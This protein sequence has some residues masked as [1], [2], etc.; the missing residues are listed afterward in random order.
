MIVHCEGCRG[1]GPLLVTPTE[2]VVCSCCG[3]HLSHETLV[4]LHRL[5]VTQLFELK[6]PPHVVQFLVEQRMPSVAVQFF[7]DLPRAETMA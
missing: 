1:V 2:G 4:E 5:A 7:L 6:L 3:T